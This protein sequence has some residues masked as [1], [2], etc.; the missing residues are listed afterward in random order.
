MEVVVPEHVEAAASLFQRSD[1]L[2]ALLFILAHEQDPA[3]ACR[4]TSLA[5]DRGEN[6]VGRLVVDILR[7]VEPQPVELILLDPVRD[8]RQYELAYRAGV[9]AIEIERRSPVGLIAVCEV[10]GRELGQIVPVWA[11][12]V[13]DHVEDDRRARA[14]APGR[15]T[16]ACHRDC[17]R[18]AWVRTD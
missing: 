7:C 15:Q 6:M 18:D 3:L 5:R 13:V 2:N 9:L 1:K 4:R 12:M 10:V 17:R 16:V 8:V 11:E 14:R